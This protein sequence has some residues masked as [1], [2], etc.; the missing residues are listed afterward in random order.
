MKGHARVYAS[1]LSHELLLGVKEGNIQHIKLEDKVGVT[2]VMLQTCSAYLY[3]YCI[4]Q[5]IHDVVVFY[6]PGGGTNF[7]R[8]ERQGN[9]G[10][11]TEEAEYY[12]IHGYESVYVVIANGPETSRWGH[13]RDK[14]RLEKVNHTLREG[15]HFQPHESFFP[16]HS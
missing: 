2:V 11:A 13:L 4:G 7:K 5:T 15:I 9:I 1:G 8:Q 10:T 6:S 3:C 12:G 14:S 16:L